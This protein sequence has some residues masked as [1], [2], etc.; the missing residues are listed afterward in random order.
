MHLVHCSLEQNIYQTR[1]SIDICNDYNN[2]K[3]VILLI[4]LKQ[5]HLVHYSLVLNVSITLSTK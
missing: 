3:S 1:P 5:M 4:Q 2:I